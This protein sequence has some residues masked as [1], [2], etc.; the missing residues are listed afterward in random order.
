IEKYSFRL[1]EVL[2]SPGQDIP[3]NITFYLSQAKK[4]VDLCVFTISDDVLSGCIKAISERG[5]K[6][7]IITDNNKMRDSGSQIKELARCGIE[8]KVDNSRYHMHNKFGIIDNRIAFTGSYNWTYTAKLHNQE[9]LVITTNFTIVHRFID[10]F[11]TLWEQMFRLNVKTGRN[12]Q[13]RASV[14]LA[15]GERIDE[16]DETMDTPAPQT[17]KPDKRAERRTAN[18]D[19]VPFGKKGGD[20]ARNAESGD[21]SQRQARKHRRGR[22]R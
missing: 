11:T 9:N 2:F 7:R 20:R 10:E 18:A 3:E 22:N 21:R 1:H 15:G 17:R 5:V 4:S 8:V 12:G 13:L 6:V 14:R 16:D 19:A